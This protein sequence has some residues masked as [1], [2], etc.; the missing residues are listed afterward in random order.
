MKTLSAQTTP[1]IISTGFSLATTQNLAAVY[2]GYNEMV[3]PFIRDKAIEFCESYQPAFWSFYPLTNGGAFFAP[4]LPARSL[5]VTI[6]NTHFNDHL[7]LDAIGII[8][9]LAA[10]YTLACQTQDL[11]FLTQYDKLKLYAASLKEAGKILSA[12]HH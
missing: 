5:K 11:F 7:S 9:T 4:N 6:A 8:C 1:R 2:G 10:Y 3:F 12:I